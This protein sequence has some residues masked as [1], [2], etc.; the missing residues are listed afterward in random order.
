MLDLHETEVR[1]D[2]NSEK[3]RKSAIASNVRKTNRRNDD[4]KC[5]TGSIGKVKKIGVRK[6][7]EEDD[8]DGAGK[9]HHNKAEI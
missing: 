8:N 1:E 2:R 3:K 6:V 9:T 4:F 5:L 7:Q